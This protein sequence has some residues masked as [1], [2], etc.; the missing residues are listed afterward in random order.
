[1]SP[2]YR[3]IEDLNKLVLVHLQRC[4]LKRAPTSIVVD[5]QEL[6]ETFTVE[7]DQQLRLEEVPRIL[8][9]HVIQ[10]KPLQGLPETLQGF[11]L[12]NMTPEDAWDFLKAKLL[13]IFDGEDVRID[14]G[15]VPE[16]PTEDG[17]GKPPGVVGPPALLAS[18]SI[19]SAPLRLRLRLLGRRLASR[20]VG[21]ISCMA[22]EHCVRRKRTLARSPGA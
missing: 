9:G 16:L 20:S 11:G 22:V 1:V 4:V 5:L 19:C 2:N 18:H 8:W 10:P 12:N 7:D 21:W 15:S 13:V 17:P 3:A 14:S 6:L